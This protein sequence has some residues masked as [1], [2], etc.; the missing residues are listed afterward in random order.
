[1]TPAEQE[2]MIEALLTLARSHP[3]QRSGLRAAGQRSAEQR[4]VR[5]EAGSVGRRHPVALGERCCER[6]A[7]PE[8]EE[9]YEDEDIDEDET[10][11]A[12]EEREDREDKEDYRQGRKRRRRRRDE[13][14]WASPSERNSVMSETPFRIVCGVIPCSSL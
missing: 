10:D 13:G 5:C 1:M 7:E 9:V 4:H 14:T 8:E 11:E 3:G 2:R 6:A 12:R